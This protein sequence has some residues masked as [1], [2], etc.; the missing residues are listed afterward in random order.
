MTP[1]RKKS[2]NWNPCGYSCNV[3]S[4]LKIQKLVHSG[5]K[6]FVCSQCKYSCNRAS[7]LREHMRSHSGRQLV[8]QSDADMGRLWWDLG[9][10]KIKTAAEIII[11]LSLFTKNSLKIWFPTPV[12]PKHFYIQHAPKQENFKMTSE[13]KMHEVHT[14]AKK[15]YKCNQCG[16]SFKAPS[17]LKGHMRVHRGEKPIPDNC[18]R[19]GRR[20]QCKFFWPV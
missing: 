7:T 10:I 20:R 1:R 19:R 13:L 12:I 8:S 11:P 15:S 9:P 18:R 3:P 4:H 16:H 6:T 5:E 14:D 17:Y 2:Y